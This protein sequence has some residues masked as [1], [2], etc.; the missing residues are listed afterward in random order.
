MATQPVVWILYVFVVLELYAL[1]LRNH[2]G[3]ASLSRWVLVGALVV[4]IT[5]AAVSLLADLSRPAGRFPLLVYMGVVERGLAF[6]LVIFLVLITSFLMWTPVAL[7]RNVVVHT[8][9]YSAYFL[10][11]AAALLVR[12]VFGYELVARVSI[13][14]F[15]SHNLCLLLWILLLN[16]RGEEAP[17]VVRRI[18][19][20]SDE[21]LITRQL[22]AVN[23]FLLRSARKQGQ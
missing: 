2:P 22:D 10:A 16:R 17:V 18:W 13:G 5:V 21:D 8:M 20:Q 11:T 1:A 9:V 15:F 12:N 4:S 23:S 7:P 19:R 14:V 3:I 6:S